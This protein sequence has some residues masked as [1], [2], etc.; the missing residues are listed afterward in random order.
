M[1]NLSDQTFGLFTRHFGQVFKNTTKT[2]I[3][4]DLVLA[5]IIRIT[6][7]TGSL[8]MVELPDGRKGFADKEGFVN[9][10]SIFNQ[11]KMDTAQMV[12]LAKTFMGI[13][14]L[15]GGKSSKAIDCSGFT[16]LLFIFQGLI[17]QRDASQQVKYGELVKTNPDFTNFKTG[18]LLFFGKKATESSPEKVSH[19]GI[20]IGNGI[21][22]HS[23]GLVR[24]S[25]LNPSNPYFDQGYFNIFLRARRIL[26]SGGKTGIEKIENNVLYKFFIK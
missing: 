24:I 10:K 11:E 7:K 4:S 17:L 6:G 21:F 18:D 19:V 13:S 8:Y 12:K 15:W 2:E 1:E 25:S 23:S 14:Y 20:Y 9:V 3:V 16:S 22:I 5:D 26:N